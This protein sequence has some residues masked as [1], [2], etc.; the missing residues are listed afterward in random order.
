MD[1]TRNPIGM[2]RICVFCGSR[3]GRAPSWRDAAT[4]LGT[5]IAASGM[6]LVYGGGGRGMMELWRTRPLPRRAGS[7]E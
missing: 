1:T 4:A 3:D 5:T 6:E 7:S 2:K